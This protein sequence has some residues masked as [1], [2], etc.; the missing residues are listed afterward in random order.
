MVRVTGVSTNYINVTGITTLP[1]VADGYLPQSG[2]GTVSVPDLTL[3]KS[4][5][6]GQIDNTLYTR[7]PRQLISNVDLTD[8]K[9]IGVAGGNYCK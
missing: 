4:R 8:V 3:L 6:G 9:V 2:V 5:L 7:M 1:G